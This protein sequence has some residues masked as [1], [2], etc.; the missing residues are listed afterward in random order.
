MMEPIAIVVEGK[1]ESQGSKTPIRRGN[2]IA[3]IEGTGTKP[4]RLKDWRDSIRKLLPVLE[5]PIEEAVHVDI[6]FRFDRP[7]S[8][9]VAKR[10]HMIVKPDVDKLS[11]AV[12]D[13]ITW[14][15][16]TGILKDD[17]RVVRLTATKTYV[18]DDSANQGATV[19]I[20]SLELQ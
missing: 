1:P 3:L 6:Q 9:S 13:A 5:T 14:N 19:L 7:K 20:T 4:K 17:S 10:P 18:T 16:E 8:V 2:H 11:R 12:L 15:G